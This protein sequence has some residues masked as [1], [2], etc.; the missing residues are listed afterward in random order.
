MNWIR[1]LIFLFVT[2]VVGMTYVGA[3]NYQGNLLIYFLFALLANALLVNGF[4]KSAIY[5]DTF[6]GLFLWMGFWLKLTVNISFRSGIFIEPTGIFDGSAKSF[7]HVLLISSC[8]FSGLLVASLLR[9][10]FFTF[11]SKMRSFKTNALFLFYQSHRTYFIV[12]FIV[13]VIF[14]AASNLWLGIYQRGMVP[15]KILPFGLN[16]IY[17]WLLQ[18][19]LASISALIIRFEIELNRGISLVSVF[20]SLLESFFSSISLLSRG[21]ILNSTALGIG[22]LRT[23]AANRLRLDKALLFIATISFMLLFTISVYTVN[24]F[25]AS[26]WESGES[27]SPTVSILTHKVGPLLSD[28]WVG[29]EGVMAVSFSPE[30][31]WKLWRDAWQ[32]KFMIGQLSLYDTKFIE[33]PYKHLTDAE[34]T[35][36]HFVSLPGVVAFMF[37]PG[38]F[39]FLFAGLIVIG[40]V[41]SFFEIAAFYLAGQNLVLCSLVGQVVAYRLACFGYVP[42]QSYLLFIAILLN[43]ILIF[44]AEQILRWR[45]RNSI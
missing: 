20:T 10:C 32:E 6:I 13:L 42:G 3:S 23:I 1:S 18:F 15:Q 2:F 26:K 43:L 5:F 39:I 41:A 4:I 45:I 38:S 7:D 24:Y 17:K 31:G 29:V 12:A 40:L 22:V 28:R 19:G 34:K 30:L 44:F 37:Y 16:G 11:P 25:R 14:T 27:A 9:R 36:K 21:M 33:S 35:I 8:G